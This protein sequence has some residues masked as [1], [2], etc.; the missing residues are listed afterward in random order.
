MQCVQYPA[1]VQYAE[2]ATHC[3]GGKA[4]AARIFAPVSHSHVQLID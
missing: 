3:F 2:K 4:R 1:P